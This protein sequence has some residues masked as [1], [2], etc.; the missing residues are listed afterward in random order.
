MAVLMMYNHQIADVFLQEP[1]S[2]FAVVQSLVELEV[3]GD[4]GQDADPIGDRVVV[5]DWI[6]VQVGP[7]DGAVLAGRGNG[8]A[9]SLITREHG[10]DAIPFVGVARG[11]K[12]CGKRSAEHGAQS[13]TG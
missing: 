10:V 11:A 1:E 2:G 3:F 13:E 9:P 4:V 8:L 7:E 12:E 6:H 5:P